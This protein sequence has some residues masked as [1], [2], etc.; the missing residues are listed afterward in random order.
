MEK[1]TNTTITGKEEIKGTENMKTYANIIT[2]ETD[3]KSTDLVEYVE[4]QLNALR[5][6]ETY[7]TLLLLSLKENLS[8]EKNIY[9]FSFKFITDVSTYFVIS[10]YNYYNS[11]YWITHAKVKKLTDKKELTDTEKIK[12]TNLE[13]ILNYYANIKSLFTEEE[14]IQAKSDRVN[15]AFVGTITGDFMNS[16][17]NQDDLTALV[18]S[19]KS[20]RSVIDRADCTKKERDKAFTDT[21]QKIEKLCQFYAPTDT[22]YSQAMPNHANMTVT[23]KVINNVM[24]LFYN[25]LKWDSRKTGKVCGS[26]DTSGKKIMKEI[27]MVCIERFQN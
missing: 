18:E 14:V 3:G 7:T 16:G 6:G 5:N 11:M 26:N 4:N 27:I 2:V 21:R 15:V 17:I 22:V 10:M 20:T 8:T 9:D 1:T 13:T 12:K 23:K 25:G 24:S 19:I